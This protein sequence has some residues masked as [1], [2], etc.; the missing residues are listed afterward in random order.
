MCEVSLSPV[1][2]DTLD[3]LGRVL[4]FGE[5]KRLIGTWIDVNVD[6]GF[7]L[8]S[9]D[10]LVKIWPHNHKLYLIGKNP[11]AENIAEHFHKVFGRILSENGIA[12]K[13]IRVT[14]HETPNSRAEYY[15]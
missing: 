5:I 13:V 8:N 7:I 10:E 4:D 9:T 11:T 12:A 15:T 3:D 1:D 6:H 2:G 14:I